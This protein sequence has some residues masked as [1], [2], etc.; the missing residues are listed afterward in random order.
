MLDPEYSVLP[1]K[2][3]PGVAE[4]TT[5]QKVFPVHTI[6]ENGS[7]RKVASREIMAAL[8]VPERGASLHTMIAPGGPKIVAN[9]GLSPGGGLAKYARR[10]AIEAHDCVQVHIH[11][12]SYNGRPPVVAAFHA[13]TLLWA[14]KNSSQI[15]L[16]CE[17]GTSR[18]HDICE[19]LVNAAHAGA[20]F[21]TTISTTPADAEDWRTFVDRWKG[22]NSEVR[23]FGPEGLQ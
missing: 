18:H 13:P 6:H 3:L 12:E 16:W 15:A 9:V 5:G 19:W 11:A 17:L 10:L 8:L 20:R 7:Q 4:T 23:V 14:L 2:K 21:Q 22:R 1:V